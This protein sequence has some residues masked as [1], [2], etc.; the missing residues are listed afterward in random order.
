MYKLNDIIFVKPLKK[1][2][3]IVKI[4]NN[5]EYLVN[6]NNISYKLPQNAIDECVQKSKKLKKISK[7]KNSLASKLYNNSLKIKT[8]DLHGVKYAEL[9]EIVLQAISDA[10]MNGYK[11]L[12]LMHGLGHEVLKKSLPNIL[13]NISVVKSYKETEN[14]GVMAVYL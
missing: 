13:N 4:L 3:R 14:P 6:I 7:N 2:G 11:Q 8:I 12:N 10:I 9:E 5:H 1:E